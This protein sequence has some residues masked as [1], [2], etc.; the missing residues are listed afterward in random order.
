[1][2]TETVKV[3]AQA[4]QKE[5]DSLA[6]SQVDSTDSDLRYAAYGA[7]LRTALRAGTRYVAYTSDVGEAFRPVVPPAIVTAAYGISWLYLTGDVGYEAYKAHRNG[8]SPLEAAHFSEPTRVGMVA[9]KR[10][11]FQSIASMALPAL[12]IHTAVAQAKRA[13]AGVQNPRIKTWGPTVTGLAIVPVL[14]FLF[15]HPV[16]KVTDTVFDWIAA[17]LIE[18]D[19]AIA[20]EG[21]KEL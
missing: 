20:A 1:M 21:K 12:T 16:E 15:D 19:N 7:R 8:P 11:A 10:A 5:V 9:V 6:D 18:R 17:K 2:A 3:T 13:F 4:A 14:P